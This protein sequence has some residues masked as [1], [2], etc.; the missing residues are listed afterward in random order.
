MSCSRPLSMCTESC[1]PGSSKKGKEGEPFCCYDCTPC[2]KWKISEQN[3]MNDCHKCTDEKYPNKNQDF[4]IPKTVNFLSYEDPLGISLACFALSFSLI[5]IL[6]LRTFIK[7]HNTPIVKANNRELTYTLLVSLSFC[8]CCA[9]PF[10]GPPQKVICLLRQVSFGMVFSVAVSCVLAK[11]ITVVL[12]FMATKP[13]SNMRKWMGKSLATSIVLCCSLIQAGICTVWLAL[14]PPFPD[15]DMHSMTEEIILGC[16][17]GSVTMFYCVL[18]Y[19]GFLAIVSFTVAFLARKL[20]DSFNEAKFIT[21]SML[22][23]CSVWLSFVPTYL[24]TKGKYM[25]AVEIF[26][27]LASSTGLLVCIFSPKC[28]VIVLRPELNN[29]E[30]LIR[31]KE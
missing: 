31:R 20:P 16:N 17:E 3:D 14:S 8:F 10:I 21:F 23:F 12:A 5:T 29:R 4:C 26:S 27:I 22:L 13:G 1:H 24:S 25:V 6:V 15:A 18:G 7:H 11:T 28:Y 19:M 30:Q 2:P 9:L